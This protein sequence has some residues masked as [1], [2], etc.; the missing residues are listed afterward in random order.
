[1]AFLYILRC[2]DGSYYTG[3]TRTELETRVSEHNGERYGGYTAKRLPVTLVWSQEFLRI[4]DAIAAERQVK[5]WRRAEKEA[6]ITGDFAALARLASRPARSSFETAA[7]RPPQDEE[8]LMTSMVAPTHD[9]HPEEAP[10]G[11]F[12]RMDGKHS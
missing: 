1:M 7:P 11:P 9:P 5:G 6:L 10:Q 4:E 8:T 3:S 12:R 2:A